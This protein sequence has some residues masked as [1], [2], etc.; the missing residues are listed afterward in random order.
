MMAH[1]KAP[2]SAG[3]LTGAKNQNPGGADSHSSIPDFGDN[4][5]DETAERIFKVLGQIY[6]EENNLDV[7]VTVMKKKAV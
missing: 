5:T 6:A 3:T 7:T 1:K 2:M 4:F